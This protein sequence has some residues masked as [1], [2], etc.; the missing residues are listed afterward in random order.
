MRSPSATRTTPPWRSGTWTTGIV[1]GDDHVYLGGYPGAFRDLLGARSEEFWALQP[2]QTLTLDDG[3]TATVWSENLQALP[4]TD[5]VRRY[6][7]GEL[8]GVAALTRRSVGSAGGSAWYLATRV[9]DDA[10][11][12]LVDELILTSGVQP[13]VAEVPDG[14]EVTRRTALDGRSWLFVLNHTGS[15]QQVRAEGFELIGG[16]SVTGEVT[17]APG[18]VVVVREAG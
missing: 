4:G 6:A 7:G 15:E 14:V 11:Q 16:E 12:A 5:V 10:L 3:S 13:V 17:V 9:D 18:A 2:G 1:D 8:D